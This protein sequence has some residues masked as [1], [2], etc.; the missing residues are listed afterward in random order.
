MSIISRLLEEICFRL[1]RKAHSAGMV[2]PVAHNSATYSCPAYSD[3]RNSELITQFSDNF[4]PATVIGKRV[5][6]FGC[7]TGELSIHVAALGA[8]SVVGTDLSERRVEEARIRSSTLG[9]GETISFQVAKSSEKIDLPESSLDAILCFD[10][11]E[12]IMEYQAIILEWH[13][14]LAENGRVLIWW[15]VWYHPYGHHLHTMIPLPWVHLFLSDA[16]L[17]RICARI[18]ELPEFKPRIWHFDCDGKR[19]PNPYARQRKFCDLNKL[20]TRKAEVL[21][22]Q[23][24]FQI[25][26]RMTHPFS[27]D[28]LRTL[29]HL[30]SKT[31]FRDFFCGCAVYEL[32][33]QKENQ[34]AQ[35]GK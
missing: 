21:F 7:G 34:P 10:V 5:L 24:G 6:D 2:N 12:H 8:V 35:I 29:K 4:D 23:A 31:R 33:V 28:R 27:G 3:W 17:L 18:Y 25:A 14:V 9:M 13:R 19:I 11:M 1:S 20:T 16:S 26:K 22:R 32:V 30:L 15:S